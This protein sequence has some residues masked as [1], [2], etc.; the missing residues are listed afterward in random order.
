MP[1]IR[2]I[3]TADIHL[4]SPLRGLAAYEG[5]PVGLLR[6]A[7]RRAFVRLVDV[8]VDEAVDF[9]V[10]AG[11]LYD[12]DWPDHNTGLFFCRQMG[13]LRAARI[14]VY[15]ALGNHDAESEITKRLPLPDNV[16]V[17]SARAAE[18]VRL[19]SAA[20]ALHGRSFHKRETT[21]N[22]VPGYPPPVP[23][24]F[25]IG[26]LHTALEGDAQHAAY[27]P[28]SLR[29]LVA[30]GYDYWALGHVHAHAIV[31]TDPAVV[32]PGNLQGRHIRETGT[33]GAVL[34]AVEG[35]RVDI[36]RLAVDV[37][38][39]HH[40]EV[41]VGGLSSLGEVAARVGGRLGELVAAEGDDRP[42]AVRIT[43]Y[44][45]SAAHGALFGLEGQ[46]RAEILAHAV[47]LGMDGLWVE[48][49]CVRTEAVLD[50]ETVRARGDAVA[51]IDALLEQAPD[52]ELL[53]ADLLATL[54]DLAN[55]LPPELKESLPE[56]AAI[57]AGDVADLVRR[58][59]PGLLARIVAE[60]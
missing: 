29:E 2:F 41:D 14:P 28:C 34:V 45:R 8:A 52:D 51:D 31:R 42:L 56:L 50:P 25:N 5:A 20:V 30:R 54:G 18:T 40:L 39:W 36:A 47:G 27:A 15:V 59:T 48:K 38:R 22:L 19:E 44:G 13:R 26:V 6:T 33:R 46:L 49:V 1:A 60:C 24:F 3:H 7:T 12:G 57:R 11:D 23:G 43:L 58:V 37:L 55:Q 16:H 9:L 4:D 32:Y 53:A 21:E 35:E 17:F 10:I